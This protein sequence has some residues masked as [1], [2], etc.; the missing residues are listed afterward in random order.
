MDIAATG[1]I[2]V[3]ELFL[4]SYSDVSEVGTVVSVNCVVVRML[5]V[6]NFRLAAVRM[7]YGIQLR[8]HGAGG[9]TLVQRG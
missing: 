6:Y 4:V 7:V 9:T 3:F 8:T 5:S 2:E 1:I